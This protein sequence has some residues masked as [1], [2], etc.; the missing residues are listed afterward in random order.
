MREYQDYKCD[1]FHKYNPDEVKRLREYGE[2]PDSVKIYLKANGDEDESVIF[3]YANEEMDNESSEYEE[4]ES[5]DENLFNLNDEN[6]E[7]IQKKIHSL[8]EE[9]EMIENEIMDKMRKITMKGGI[10]LDELKRRDS[11]DDI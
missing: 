11:I 3:D 5:E 8:R 4:G 7:T 10:Q 6:D 2:I 9:E 1:A